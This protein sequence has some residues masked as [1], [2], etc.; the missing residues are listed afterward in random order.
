MNLIV[1]FHNF[2]TPLQI[3]FKCTESL[4]NARPFYKSILYRFTI[5]LVKT[6]W[7]RSVGFTNN[8]KLRSTNFS[9]QYD[10][11]SFIIILRHCQILFLLTS[12]ELTSWH[13]NLSQATERTVNLWKI[14]CTYITVIS[15]ICDLQVTVKLFTALCNVSGVDSHFFPI[16]KKSYSFRTLNICTTAQQYICAWMLGY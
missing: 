11:Q 8:L 5:Y 15:F 7:T 13:W 16:Q 6:E 10:G 3:R 1:S 4:W 2:G 14:F 9:C 12:L